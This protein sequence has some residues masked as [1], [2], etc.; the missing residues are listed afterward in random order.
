MSESIDRAVTRRQKLWWLAAT[1]K[2]GAVV[3]AI[4]L[5]WVVFDAG[6]LLRMLLSGLFL[7][8]LLWPG[9][10]LLFAVAASVLC[11]HYSAVGLW[12][13]LLS[14]CSAVSALVMDWRLARMLGNKLDSDAV[15][16]GEKD[17]DWEKF[18]S[19]I[20]S[21]QLAGIVAEVG[22]QSPEI[23]IRIYPENT[24]DHTAQPLFSARP[25]EY[26]ATLSRLRSEFGG[27]QF[28]VIVLVRGE[29]RRRFTLLV[30][31]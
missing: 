14:Y 20:W 29:I 22:E 4:W 24:I 2:L 23:D 1:N 11:F 10:A 9:P 3:T 15:A 7:I 30:T 28:L 17:V 31:G 19:E 13:P 26:R 21:E 25:E 6:G 16:V 18:S 8:F 27:G 5:L 12:L